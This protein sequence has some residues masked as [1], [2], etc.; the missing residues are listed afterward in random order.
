[1]HDGILDGGCSHKTVDRRR[2]DLVVLRARLW[3]G[4]IVLRDES[5]QE[6]GGGAWFVGPIRR[7]RCWARTV[8]S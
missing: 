1:M 8:P 4:Q 2:K 3:V 6:D 7:S 5:G